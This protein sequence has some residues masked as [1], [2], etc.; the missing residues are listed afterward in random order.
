[1]NNSIH[2][3]RWQDGSVVLIDQ[4]AIPLVERYVTCTN[5][6]QVIV[7][8][9]DL[10]VR[11]APSVVKN[12]A[13]PPFTEGTPVH[14]RLAGLSRQAHEEVKRGRDTAK[15][16]EEINEAVEELWNLKH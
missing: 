13:I 5:Y 11:G 12:L 6:R 10:T 8:I 2:T 4:R 14:R 3:I 16:E 7:A 15:I 9:N 1:M